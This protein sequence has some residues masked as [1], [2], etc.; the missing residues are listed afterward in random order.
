[1]DVEMTSK[2]RCDVDPILFVLFG[3]SDVRNNVAPSIQSHRNF[4]TSDIFGVRWTSIKHHSNLLDIRWCF[5]LIPKFDERFAYQNC[6]GR[7]LKQ[8]CFNAMDVRWTWKK[9]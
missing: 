9:I 8:R 4:W 3:T 7:T 5:T 6:Y 1:M 2:K